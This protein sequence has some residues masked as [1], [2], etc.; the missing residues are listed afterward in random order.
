MR[1]QALLAPLF[2]ALAV[3]APGQESHPAA[4]T[5]VQLLAWSAGGMSSPRLNRL[6]HER[7]IA[8]S[9]DSTTSDALLAGGVEP[10]LLQDLRTAP[11]YKPDASGCPASLVRAGEL[12]RQKKYQEAQSDLAE[13]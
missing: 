4:V 2:I 6:V 9:L 12:I 13:V 7:G 5:C 8:I 1:L 11:A 10:A 3:S